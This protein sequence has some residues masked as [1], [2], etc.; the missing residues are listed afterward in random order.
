[1]STLTRI[2]RFLLILVFSSG[3]SFSNAAA[4][5]SG[6]LIVIRAPN[7]G[8]NLAANLKIDGRTVGNVV[9]GRRYDHLIPAGRHVLTVSAVPNVDLRQPTSI[10]VNI[11]PGGGTYILP[12]YGTPTTCIFDRRRCL[13]RRWGNSGCEKRYLIFAR[14]PSISFRRNARKVWPFTLPSEPTLRMNALIVSSSGASNTTTA[15]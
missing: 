14:I 2:S 6:R 15:S 13:L 7:F 8:W 11:R 3:V 10:T 5:P 12:L 9:Q 4:Q 1:M